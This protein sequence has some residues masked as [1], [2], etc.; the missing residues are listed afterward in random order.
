MSYTSFGR[1]RS[2]KLANKVTFG[3]TVAAA[4]H[5][6]ALPSPFTNSRDKIVIR[7][8]LLLTHGKADDLAIKILYMTTVASYVT[9]GPFN[10]NWN[11]LE[12]ITL[13][14]LIVVVDDKRI[15]AQTHNYCLMLFENFYY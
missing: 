7:L 10:Q 6:Y 11:Q 15:D 5:C 9:G 13:D 1:A 12:D 2:T 3:T 4:L 8:Q 14:E